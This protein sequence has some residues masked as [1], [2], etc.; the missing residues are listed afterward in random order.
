MKIKKNKYFD[1]QSSLVEWRLVFWVTFG[2]FV[3]TTVIY[4]IWASGEVQPW[5]YPKDQKS[6]E[7]GNAENNNECEKTV[8][9]HQ[10]Q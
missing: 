3:V 5:N 10:K 2:I 1:L 7:Y 6:A 9:F 8:E 4:S